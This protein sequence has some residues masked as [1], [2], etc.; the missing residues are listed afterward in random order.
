MK[1]A[2]LIFEAPKSCIQC[3]LFYEVD[4]KGF[5][6]VIKDEILEPHTGIDERCELIFR[7]DVEEMKKLYDDVMRKIDEYSN[8]QYRMRRCNCGACGEKLSV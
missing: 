8:E 7:D 3:R 1:I 2:N 5:C 4:F 6:P